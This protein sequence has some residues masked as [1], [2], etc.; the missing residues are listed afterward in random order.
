[1]GFSH[2]NCRFSLGTRYQVLAAY[3]ALIFDKNSPLVFVLLSLSISNSIASTGDSGFSTR[4]SLSS[5]SLR[6]GLGR[7]VAGSGRSG[8]AAGAFGRLNA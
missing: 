6:L 7:S 8:A 5:Y 3:N 2:W 4:N 1:M